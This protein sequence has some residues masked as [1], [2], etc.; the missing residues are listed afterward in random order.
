[1][2]IKNALQTASAEFL[3]V[4]EQ[5]ALPVALV[6]FIKKY[7][8]AYILSPFFALF[9]KGDKPLKR[10]EIWNNT[11]NERTKIPDGLFESDFG[12]LKYAKYILST[13]P[14]FIPTDDGFIATGDRTCLDLIK[15]NKGNI[16]HFLSMVFPDVRLKKYIEIRI[17]DAMP[18]DK[19]IE[20]A[21][22]IKGIFYSGKIDMLLKRYENVRVNDILNA[23]DEIMNKGFDAVIYLKDAKEELAFLKEVAICK[24]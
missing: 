17:A 15:E 7:R 14:I 13:K 11:D 21:E 2:K 20:Y 8:L 1:M 24:K 3:F 12:F 16:E 5:V 10:I 4:L 18:L 22:F 6:K 9:G 23:K 19:A